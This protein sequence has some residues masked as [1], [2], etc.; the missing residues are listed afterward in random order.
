MADKRN[1]QLK[2]CANG[3]ITIFV[4]DEQTGVIHD[5]HTS[6]SE[7][8]DSLKYEA[9]STYERIDDIPNSKVNGSVFESIK[10]LFDSIVKG[11]NDI[12]DVR[13]VSEDEPE[14]DGE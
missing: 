2:A 6:D 14:I 7:I 3:D 13:R 4:E 12:N 5:N 10:E 9:G 1:V 8:F 11:I